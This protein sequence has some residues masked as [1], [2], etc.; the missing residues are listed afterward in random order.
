MILPGNQRGRTR[1]AVPVFGSP[2]APVDGWIGSSGGGSSVTLD[3]DG[4][5]TIELRPTAVQLL[6]GTTVTF[7]Y[8]SG[9]SALTS[10]TNVHTL[11]AAALR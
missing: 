8:A 6:R 5:G 10:T 1:I 2:D 9:D 3:G 4:A 7:R 11:L